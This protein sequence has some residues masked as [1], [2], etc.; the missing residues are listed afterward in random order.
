MYTALYGY[1]L[2]FITTFDLMV[3][4]FGFDININLFLFDLLYFYCVQNPKSFVLRAAISP[5]HLRLLLP[6]ISTG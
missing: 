1:S 6:G 4:C 2:L 5:V 3:G